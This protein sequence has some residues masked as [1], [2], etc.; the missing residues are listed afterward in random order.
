MPNVDVYIG[1][2][3]H[4]GASTAATRITMT[5]DPF[6]T[7][8]QV[9]TIYRRLKQRLAPDIGVRSQGERRYE[10]ARFVAPHVAVT[11]TPPEDRAGP[12]RRPNTRDGRPVPNIQP[13]GGR[14]WTS[15]MH[16]WNAQ[17]AAPGPTPRRA[18]YDLAANFSRDAQTALR[19]ILF[20]AWRRDLAPPPPLA[21]AVKHRRRPTAT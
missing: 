15:L 7:P 4:G 13:T 11:W 8:N 10:V 21:R 3:D 16:E 14:T 17:A 2:I 20:P 5:L 12:G 19:Q 9:A 6:L 1:T 18:R